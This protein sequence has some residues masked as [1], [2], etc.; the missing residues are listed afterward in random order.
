M[1][2][3]DILQHYDTVLFLFINHLVTNPIWDAFWVIIT[4]PKYWIAPLGVAL[5][6]LIWKGGKRGRIA[7][8]IAVA[9]VGLSDVISAR[10]LKPGIGR[11]RPCHELENVRLL[12]SCGGK[13]AFPSS[14]AANT[15]A[16]A[17]TFAFFYRRFAGL[18]VAFSLLIGLSRIV[19]GV[20]YPGDV[21]GGFI[22]GCLIAGGLLLL[23]RQLGR[24]DK[25]TVRGVSLEE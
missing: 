2:F 9:A 23:Y 11:I 1:N 13:H 24:S 20:H 12:V 8:I 22:L 7:L 17:V 16:A 5:V 3:F 18:W 19:V 4:T 21:L 25:S 14:H 10:V 6:W 15:F